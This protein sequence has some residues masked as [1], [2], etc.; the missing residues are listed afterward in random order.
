ME[1]TDAKNPKSDVF[2]TMFQSLS[3][4]DILGADLRHQASAAICAKRQELKMSQA[5]FAAFMGVS[6]SMVSKWESFSYNFSLD[7]IGE[8]FVKLDIPIAFS[9]GNMQN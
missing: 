7:N 4:G 1:I 9:V 8:I 6:Q 5:E 2:D 3:K